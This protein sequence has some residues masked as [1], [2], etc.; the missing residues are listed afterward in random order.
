VDGIV[1]RVRVYQDDGYFPAADLDRVVTALRTSHVVHP[2]DL[3]RS[4][5]R[6]YAR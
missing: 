2:P 1:E 3:L 4:F 5:V 6:R